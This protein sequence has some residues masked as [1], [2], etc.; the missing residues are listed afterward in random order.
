MTRAQIKSFAQSLLQESEG[1]SGVDPVLLDRLVDQATNEICRATSCYFL[2]YT[3]DLVENQQTYCAPPLLEI[4][5]VI[6]TH[7]NGDIWNLT[8]YTA[9][10]LDQM[11][12]GWWRP[13]IND[14]TVN[15]G[16]PV[17]YIPD[18]LN[19]VR[20][21]PIP[22]YS[23][24]SGAT[25]A[26]SLSGSGIGSIS[27]VDGGSG[28]L[29][30]P[31]V[32]ITDPTGSGACATA[33]ISGGVVTGVTVTQ[34]G[35]NYTSPTV[36][37]HAGGLTFEGFA[38]PDDA[39]TSLWP[40]DTDTCP[41]PV[42]GH[43]GVA[44][45]VAHL[46]CLQNPTQQ[47]LLRVQALYKEHARLKGYVESEAAKFSDATKYRAHPGGGRHWSLGAYMTV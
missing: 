38:V 19:S 23:L 41:I 20:L 16:D 45:R 9:K 29:A 33:T 3:A 30:P 39:G 12:G 10:Q 35:T 34:G 15:Q 17:C 26:A 1:A 11:T 7:S 13:Q 22:N 37:F 6:A 14:P 44:Y 36:A 4:R 5:S 18:G 47:N 21:F 43:E 31:S 46:R 25:G 2:Q 28:Y 27:V 8:P 32:S 40:L 42:R 24:G